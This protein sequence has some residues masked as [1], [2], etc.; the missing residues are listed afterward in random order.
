MTL[1]VR[2]SDGFA[3]ATLEDGAV[4]E[5]FAAMLPLQLTLNDPVGQAKSGHL[6][7]R[8]ILD[9][10]AARTVDPYAGGIY[11]WPPT[12]TIAVVYDDLGQTIPSQGQC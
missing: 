9:H 1:R 2:G 11:Y 5:A 6:P 8:I 10:D 3:I 12:G 7:N 4:G